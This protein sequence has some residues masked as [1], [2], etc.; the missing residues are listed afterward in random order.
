MNGRHDL[1]GRILSPSLGKP[2]FLNDFG[3]VLTVTFVIAREDFP[4]ADW[5]TGF[6]LQPL[7]HQRRT[8]RLKATAEPVSF[9]TTRFGNAVD[10]IIRATPGVVVVEVPLQLTQ[11]TLWGRNADARY[12][13]FDLTHARLNDAA[14][15]VVAVNH[16]WDDFTVAFAT[17]LHVARAW[18]DIGAHIV[19]LR[20][21]NGAVHAL[22]DPTAL[23]TR[24]AFEQSFV[25]PNHNLEHFIQYANRRKRKGTLDLIVLGGDLVDYIYESG[26]AAQVGTYAQSN[27]Y[28]FEEIVRGKR[29]GDELEVPVLS[30]TG[31]H[32]YRLN[33]YRHEAYGLR[34]V[35]LHDLQTMYLLNLSVRPRFRITKPTDIRGI[36]AR[37]GKKH[38]LSYYYFHINPFSKYALDLG[39]LRMVLLDTGRDALVSPRSLGYW[40]WLRYL[41]RNL[42]N[43]EAPASEGLTDEQVAFLEAQADG[44][45]SC[46][47]VVLH[48]PP[49]DTKR[50]RTPQGADFGLAKRVE[51]QARGMVTDAFSPTKQRWTKA[52]PG[53]AFTPLAVGAIRTAIRDGALVQNQKRLLRIALKHPVGWFGFS[54]HLHRALGIE[55]DRTTGIAKP[56]EE[57]RVDKNYTPKADKSYFFVSAALGQLGTGDAVLDGPGFLEFSV[58]AAG[59]RS[60]RRRRLDCGPRRYGP[61]H[62]VLS[63]VVA[64][65]TR[66]LVTV[67]Q[68]EEIT[69]TIAK[70]CRLAFTFFL[71]AKD[72]K[73]WRK[74]PRLR[75]VPEDPATIAVEAS[76]P[77]DTAKAQHY[78]G[79]GLQVYVQGFL[80]KDAA[81]A[82]FKVAAQDPHIDPVELVVT[83]RL[84]D[85]T[86][87]TAVQRWSWWLPYSLKLK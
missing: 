53:A 5:E 82:S 15:A 80:M 13:L 1:I 42:R 64:G 46:M 29:G 59:V 36:F 63:T 10:D 3:D 57:C 37:T 71:L 8:I 76:N 34:H 50:L 27:L 70:H 45:R 17:D 84:L 87:K 16:G 68:L 2:C 20:G 61:L 81:R 40:R 83:A 12:E 7:G 11:N 39:T 66:L 30:Q 18:R 14:H 19:R 56:A 69:S 79:A 48:A 75:L 85:Y 44:D 26:D 49:L 55:I 23:F 47:A 67:K 9:K 43:F 72:V 24:E 6:S 38:S 25:N 74:G 78:F 86:R 32:D 62:A 52:R 73:P 31:N 77:L 28:L 58:N 4:C 60:V 35:G 51:S 54:G 21:G 65:D 22:T 33:A 41:L